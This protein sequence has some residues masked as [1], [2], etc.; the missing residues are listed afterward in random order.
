MASLSKILIS[1]VLALKN[2]FLYKIPWKGTLF[3]A[4]L[5]A[6][7]F[8][9]DLRFLSRH[10][11]W[12][13]IVYTHNIRSDKV[14]KIFFNPH[15][16]GFESTGYIFAKF[17]KWAHG[18]DSLMFGLRLR[19]LAVAISFIFTLMFAYWRMYSDMVGAVLL[20]LGV[21]F[22]QGFWFYAQHNDTPLIH[23]CLTACLYLYCVWN[24]KKGWSAGKLFFAYLLQVWNVYFHQSDTIFLTFV[25]ASVLFS[26]EWGGAK[27]ELSSKMK[28][29]LIY[30]FGTVF[31]L[32]ASYLYLGFV[33]LGRDLVSPTTSERNFANWLFLY[34]SQEKWGASDGPKN[35]VM[36][37]YRG[38]GDAF[39]NFEGVRNG[40][41]IRAADFTDPKAYPYNL[42][43]YFWI[44]ILSVATINLIR[45]WKEFKVELVLLFLWIGPSLLFYTWWEGY[46][47]EFWVST[48]IGLLIFA[49]LVLRSLILSPAYFGT[50]A[51]TH[52]LL[53]AYLLLLFC[54]NFTF[55]TYPRSVKPTV[56]FIEGIEDK[57]KEITPEPVYGKEWE[58]PE[59]QK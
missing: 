30:L 41:R 57:Y 35:Y 48:V 9:F 27:F 54:V 2:G 13:S 39:L 19:T 8:L 47:F 46:F 40:L 23:S 42:N 16:I 12:D 32:T 11:D 33:V 38:I 22:T 17:W 28:W 3:L 50:R 29:I 6:A 49:T 45:L 5:A 56:S 21:H 37:F 31:T 59:V 14:A 24:A 25:P 18:P 55:S 44:G 53:L 15:H 26:K 52:L 1:P 20:G 10:Y 51:L 58:G 43:L 4:L 7:L 34:A 36:N